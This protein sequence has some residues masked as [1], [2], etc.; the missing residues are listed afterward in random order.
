MFERRGLNVSLLKIT[1]LLA[2]FMCYSPH[3]IYIYWLCYWTFVT[4]N[5]VHIKLF[6]SLRPSDTYIPQTIIWTKAGSL[7]I[8]ALRT[9]SVKF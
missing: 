3:L 8:G 7:L 4:N 6:N 9:I 1:Y 2:M 5:I